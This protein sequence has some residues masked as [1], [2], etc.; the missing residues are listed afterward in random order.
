MCSNKKI[1]N[2]GDMNI[3]HTRLT[4]FILDKMAKFYKAILRKMF[5]EVFSKND[6]RYINNNAHKYRVLL[7]NDNFYGDRALN[8][9]YCKEKGKN[10]WYA[11]E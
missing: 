10:V 5:A 9:E 6:I 2:L 7:Y 8:I 11:Y 3:I 4:S 1:L